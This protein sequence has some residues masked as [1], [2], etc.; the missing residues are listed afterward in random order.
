M[1]GCDGLAE[2]LQDRSSSQHGLR[3][4]TPIC[5][6]CPLHAQV[7][8]LRATLKHKAATEAALRDELRRVLAGDGLTPSPLHKTARPAQ[9]EQ[10]TPDSARRGAAAAFLRAGS[11]A[12][13]IARRTQ[14]AG[15]AAAGQP[16]KRAGSVKAVSRQASAWEQQH[17][18]TGSKAES[19]SMGSESL[20]A[21]EPSPTRAL[22]R[23]QEQRRQQQGSRLGEHQP[24]QPADCELLSP[25]SSSGKA[26][27]PT[28][29]RLGLAAQSPAALSAKL[30][31]AAQ[32]APPVQD[33]RLIQLYTSVLDEQIALLESDLAQLADAPSPVAQLQKRA[34]AA[35]AAPLRKGHAAQREPAQQPGAIGAWRSNGAFVAEA[36]AGRASAG[37]GDQG[38]RGMQQ[39]M[40]PGGDTPAPAPVDPHLWH[41]NPLAASPPGKHQRLPVLP[42][43]QAAEAAADGATTVR[44]VRSPPKAAWQELLASP[45][46]ARPSAGARA[47]A[48][49]AEED[50]WAWAVAHGNG[51]HSE[52]ASSP[53]LR[54]AGSEPSFVG[55]PQSLGEADRAAS[56]Q[57]ELIVL[58]SQQGQTQQLAVA[59]PAAS[60]GSCGASAGPVASLSRHWSLP[61]PGPCN[62]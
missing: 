27:L 41:S 2:G 28:K 6:C 46:A 39:L 37:E 43:P 5:S 35:G 26:G 15:A 40:R 4:P 42:P 25:P 33:G 11:R 10:Q 16:S 13:S 9:Q 14:A 21:A 7:K 34:V 47:A 30:P 56:E 61:S 45:P 57:Q 48:S 62:S 36:T 3:L 23:L 17:G 58:A 22:A 49:A 18:I 29:Q 38:G 1:G 52:D 54:M 60:N 51:A 12:E 50:E 55:C 32:P 19:R 44:P 8:Q 20:I 24:R 59:L 31:A 53:S